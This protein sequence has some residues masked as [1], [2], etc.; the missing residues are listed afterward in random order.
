MRSMLASL[1]QAAGADPRFDVAAWFRGQR[2]PTCSGN[3]AKVQVL[4]AIYLPLARPKNLEMVQSIAGVLP[5]RQRRLRQRQ[6]RRRR[7]GF[8][9]RV[10]K[11]RQSAP[12]QLNNVQ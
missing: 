8:K 7:R 4:T 1:Q 11:H 12:G 9:T 6:W 5:R 3:W 10:Q 2:L